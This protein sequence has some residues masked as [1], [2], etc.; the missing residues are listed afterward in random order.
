MT[1]DSSRRAVFDTNE[2]L[3][4]ILSYLPFKE[5]FVLQSVSRQWRGVIASSPGL[6]ETM[7]L[8]PHS[9]TSKNTWILENFAY[10]APLENIGGYRNYVELA[11]VPRFRLNDGRKT[12][13]CAPLIPL[14]LN[15]VFRLVDYFHVN[16]SYDNGWVL[17]RHY[18]VALLGVASMPAVARSCISLVDTVAMCISPAALRRDCSLRDLYI[19]EPPCRVADVKLLVKFQG[20]KPC[21]PRLTNETLN[22]GT[23]F[24]V[25]SES[26]ITI[27]DI[28][29]AASNSTEFNCC[30]FDD[31]YMWKDLRTE[32]EDMISGTERPDGLTGVWDVEDITLYIDLLKGDARPLVVTEDERL[33]VAI[34]ER[35]R[36]AVIAEGI[37]AAVVM[38]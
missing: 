11:G 14:T 23:G 2:L 38:D 36:A 1:L 31:G 33:A 18:E 26:G 32:M 7:F 19:S 37:G 13:R 16:D 8:R 12:S 30:E 24:R 28:L 21:V 6:Q 17:N 27:G 3:E 25:E 35:D 34:R 9:T 10:H 29:K 15:P 20:E 22:P 5:L 4:N